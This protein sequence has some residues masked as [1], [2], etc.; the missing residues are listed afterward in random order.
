[1]TVQAALNRNF[2]FQSMNAKT[3]FAERLRSAMCEA[4]YEP[5]PSVLEKGFNIRYWGQPVTFQAAAR[6]LKGLS[7]PEQDKLQV[8]ADWLKVEPHALRFGSQAGAIRQRRARWDAAISGPEREV[9]E[10][11]IN[12]PAEQKRVARAVILALAKETTETS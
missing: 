12:L 11:F 6:W 2:N 9:L 1:M 5:R 8:L 4:G 10:V 3:E 7:I